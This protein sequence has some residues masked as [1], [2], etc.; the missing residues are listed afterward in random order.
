MGSLFSKPKKIKPPEANYGEDIN[1]LIQGYQQAT[2]Q[3]VAF[4]Q[5]ARP[6]YMGL[7]LA[8]ASNFLQGTQGQQGYF[9]LQNLATENTQNLLNKSK[10]N[11]IQGMQGQTQDI[12]SLFNQMSPEVAAAL[13][14]Q[15]Q[16]TQ[17]A[18]QQAQGLS[19]EDKRIAD[20]A[21][22][23]QGLASGRVSDNITGIMG[24]L[25]RTGIMD[26]RR[27]SASQMN[28]SLFNLGSGYQGS[29][30]SL[31]Q[32]PSQAY[33]IG[34]QALN[35]GL[36]QMGNAN[37]AYGIMDTALNLGA[38]NRNNQFQAQQANAQASA[39]RSSAL[40]SLAGGVGGAILGGPMGASIGASI[41]GMFGEKPPKAT[42]VQ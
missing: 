36:S 3:N 39:S 27:G 31:L 4:E 1:K 32:Q 37:P 7:N 17:T 42:V 30:L 38:T 28:Q 20:Q 6:Q 16:L 41:G 2:P 9:S 22:Y 26:Q 25:N 14:N 5:S 13:K 10:Q 8:D 12:I 35:V 18:N 19:G 21:A 29:I 23:E 33:A 15:A 11:E 40:L 34:N 24:A